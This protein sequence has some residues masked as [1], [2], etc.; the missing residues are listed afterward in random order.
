MT[1]TLRCGHI[2]WAEVAD[3]NGVRKARPVVIVTPDDRLTTSGPLEVVAITSR[4]PQPLPADHVLLPWHAQGHPRTGLN[5]KCAAVCTWLA[6]IERDDIQKVVGIVPGTILLDISRRIAAAQPGQ[7]ATP[8]SKEGPSEADNS[9]SEASS[10]ES[11]G[12]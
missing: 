3:E 7:P 11:E 12:S 1:P 8:F 9:P 5:R 4:L 10:S 6:R 2:V